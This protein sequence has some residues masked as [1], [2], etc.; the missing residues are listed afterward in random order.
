M[1]ASNDKL[2]YEAAESGDLKKV[3]ELL[4]KGVGT[5][6][7]HEVSQNIIYSSYIIIIDNSVVV[8]VVVDDD[9]D[10]DD[11]DDAYVCCQHLVTELKIIYIFIYFLMYNLCLKY[12]NDNSNTFDNGDD[13][14]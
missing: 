5:G 8:V 4:S 1:S 7:R 13:D 2:L 11:D 12:T 9:D 3:K 6:Y 10:D 14:L